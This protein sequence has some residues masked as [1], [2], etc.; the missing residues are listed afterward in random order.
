MIG[1]ISFLNTTPLCQS[2]TSFT[3]KWIWFEN[4]FKLLSPWILTSPLQL[5]LPREQIWKSSNVKT[6]EKF[7][8]QQLL[9]FWSI[10]NHSCLVAWLN[11]RPTICFSICNIWKQIFKSWKKN[12]RDNKYISNL[13]LSKSCS[14]ESKK[15]KCLIHR[16]RYDFQIQ[17][18]LLI[19]VL[20]ST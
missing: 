14:N 8:L 7:F 20:P 9:K 6:L 5:I 13:Y 19:S 10:S 17:M 1:L 4:S 18:K 2:Q 16:Q 15:T 3:R 11:L 12:D